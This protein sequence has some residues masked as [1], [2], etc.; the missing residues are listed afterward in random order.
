M[1]QPFKR[2]KQ[3]G[4][5]GGAWVFCTKPFGFFTL[6]VCVDQPSSCGVT[7]HG[8]THAWPGLLTPE[9]YGTGDSDTGYR[10]GI[11][12]VPITVAACVVLPRTFEPG[13]G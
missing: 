2:R 6:S 11:D 4:W 12:A 3:R 1:S 9:Q 8:Q 7:E 13:E 10:L 5:K